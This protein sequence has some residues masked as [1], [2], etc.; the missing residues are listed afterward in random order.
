MPSRIATTSSISKT[1]GCLLIWRAHR[2][3]SNHPFSKIDNDCYP[4]CY[5]MLPCKRCTTE[6]PNFSAGKYS[7]S[8]KALQMLRKYRSKI[9]K[10]A[11]SP[12]SP[13]RRGFSGCKKKYRAG[14]Q[15]EPECGETHPWK[16]GWGDARWWEPYPAASLASWLLILIRH[17]TILDVIVLSIPTIKTIFAVKPS[18][19]WKGQDIGHHHIVGHTLDITYGLQTSCMLITAASVA[20]HEDTGSLPKN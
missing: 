9:A 12:A 10:H 19:T 16:Q 5:D 3:A 15:E 14:S 20:L 13:T 17:G 6:D 2:M 4:G 8:R 1:D 7:A 18:Y 11:L